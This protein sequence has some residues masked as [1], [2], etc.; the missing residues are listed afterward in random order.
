MRWVGRLELGQSCEEG[1]RGCIQPRDLRLVWNR[2]PR[3]VAGDAGRRSGPFAR[4]SA[5]LRAGANLRSLQERLHEGTAPCPHC[6]DAGRGSRS[7]LDTVIRTFA[8]KETIGYQ[9]KTVSR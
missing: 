5:S 9:G 4:S 3:V 7:L 1:A 8:P 2:M 6:K